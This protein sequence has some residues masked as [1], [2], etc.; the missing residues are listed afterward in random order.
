MRKSRQQAARQ[1][2]QGRLDAALGTVE[3][4]EGELEEAKRAVATVH[5]QVQDELWA[6]LLAA[7][8][9]L[10]KL[11]AGKVPQPQEVVGVQLEARE[12]PDDL[13]LLRCHCHLALEFLRGHEA[14]AGARL[15]RMGRGVAVS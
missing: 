6:R 13:A 4:L 1:A 9:A 12:D 11:L 2:V 3:R 15:G 14:E 8:P 7:A 10:A 5:G